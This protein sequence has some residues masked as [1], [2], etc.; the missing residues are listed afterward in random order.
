MEKL[1]CYIYEAKQYYTS[2]HYDTTFS[3]NP[4]LFYPYSAN[5]KKIK[6]IYV[7]ECCFS[8]IE[9]AG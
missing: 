9:K 5:S 7:D 1:F 2:I 6:E 3:R 4:L 8:V